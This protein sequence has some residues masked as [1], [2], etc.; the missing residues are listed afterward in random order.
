MSQESITLA[1][2]IE[3]LTISWDDL[4][5]VHRHIF[6]VNAILIAFNNTRKADIVYHSSFVPPYD[7][8]STPQVDVIIGVDDCVLGLHSDFGTGEGSSSYLCR[9]TS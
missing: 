2:S 7:G 9:N 3:K 5:N 4:D 8:V 1:F 6:R